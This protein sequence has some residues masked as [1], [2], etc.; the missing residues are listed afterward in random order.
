[1]NKK[2]DNNN[3]IEP[4]LKPPDDAKVV[5][6]YSIENFES[7][8]KDGQEE[9]SSETSED[10]GPTDETVSWLKFHEK[11][12]KENE[13][14]DSELDQFCDSF[15]TALAVTK[16]ERIPNHRSGT[17]G[18]SRNTGEKPSGSRTANRVPKTNQKSGLP[19]ENSGKRANKRETL[20]EDKKSA[21]LLALEE[22]D[23]EKKKKNIK[24]CANN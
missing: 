5:D 17:D 10:L 13:T 19:R 6:N 4:V 21:L 14:V 1:M 20:P 11:I 15:G 18:D 9:E 23:S 2:S 3:N 8:D 12:T 24:V 7:Y 22:I 16:I